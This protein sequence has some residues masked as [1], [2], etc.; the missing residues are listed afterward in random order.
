MRDGAKK[1]AMLID[2]TKFNKTFLCTDFSFN[3]VDYLIT[4]KLP[5]KEYVEHLKN[6]NCKIICPETSEY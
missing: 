4:D 2:S 3:E 6:T 1:L 5:P